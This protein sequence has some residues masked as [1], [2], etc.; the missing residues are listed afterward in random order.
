MAFCKHSFHYH[1]CNNLNY[2]CLEKIKCADSNLEDNYDGYPEVVCVF[3]SMFGA[4]SLFLCEDCEK[5]EH[6]CEDC[7]TPAHLSHD[8]DCIFWAR[9]N[10]LTDLP[11]EF[12]R[13]DEMYFE[14]A[15]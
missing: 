13:D 1:D 9:E 10:P 5:T 11:V 14:E 3:E 7:G 2:G 4:V 12:Y 15:A 6:W 8:I